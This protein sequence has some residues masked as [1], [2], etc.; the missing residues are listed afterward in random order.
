MAIDLIGKKDNICEGLYA[1]D[2][3]EKDV[4]TIKSNITILASGGA[5]KIYQYTTN[6][7][8]LREMV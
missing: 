8:T 3:D 1:F 6:P 5:S 2:N 7:Q 4:I